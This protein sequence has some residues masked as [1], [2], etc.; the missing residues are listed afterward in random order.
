MEAGSGMTTLVPVGR[1]IE[2]EV[3]LKLMPQLTIP[4]LLESRVP[5]RSGRV[6]PDERDK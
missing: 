4:L 2:E 6:A 5:G 1:I 3:Y